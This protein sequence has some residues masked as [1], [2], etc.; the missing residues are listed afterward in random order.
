[1]YSHLKR[2]SEVYKGGFFKNRHKLGWRAP[3]VCDMLINLFSLKK[4]QSIIDVGCAIGEYVATFKKYGFISWGIEGSE[5]AREF[6]VTKNVS[7]WDLRQDLSMGPCQGKYDLAISLEVAEHIE[8][9][10]AGVYL[11]NL[12]L[13]SDTILMTAAHPGQGGHGHVN[14]QEKGWWSCEMA[15]RGYRR[16]PELERGW[17]ERLRPWNHRKEINV[18]AKNV[19]VFERIMHEDVIR[20]HGR[21]NG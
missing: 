1:M 13:L 4:S 11:D 20:Q 17:V 18:Y 10:Y 16:N 9:E 12:C 8:P 14:C 2:V 5:A 3:I 19:M 21:Q 7:I 6:M 15:N